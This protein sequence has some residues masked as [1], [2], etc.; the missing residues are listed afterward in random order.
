M[1]LLRLCRLSRN[2]RA[3]YSDGSRSAGRPY[4]L[5]LAADLAF[6]RIVEQRHNDDDRSRL[7]ELPR[8]GKRR[9][10]VY[11]RAHFRYDAAFGRADCRAAGYDYSRYRTGL[12]A[13][14]FVVATMP[15]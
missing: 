11:R 7:S 6:A 14:A 4:R 8:S 2:E 10:A 3:D 9:A 5:E 12:D 15:R 1:A 13:G